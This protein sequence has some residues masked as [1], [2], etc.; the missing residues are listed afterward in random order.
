[1]VVG[2]GTRL[3]GSVVLAGAQIAEH[4]TIVDSVVGAD[5]ILKPEVSLTD[6]TLI[7]AGISIAAG[8]RISGGRVPP[9][10]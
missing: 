9:S 7:G 10:E 1:V 8:T 4:C 2:A 5:A 6:L 3:E